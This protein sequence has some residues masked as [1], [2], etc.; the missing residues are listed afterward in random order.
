MAKDPVE[1]LD[2]GVHTG[3]VGGGT[4]DPHQV[5]HKDVNAQLVAEGGLSPR[6]FGTHIGAPSLL[7]SPFWGMGKSVPSTDIRQLLPTALLRQLLKII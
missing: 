6:T 3:R 4:L 2:V 5:P 7:L 1:N